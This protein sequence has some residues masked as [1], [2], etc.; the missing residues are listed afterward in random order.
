MWVQS[1]GG[2]ILNTESVNDPVVN[3]IYD[4]VEE[5]S[6]Q[7]YEYTEAM[8]SAPPLV[9]D[10]LHEGFRLL[11]D[12]NGVVLAG[13]ELEADWGYKFITWQ[14]TPDRTAMTQG[15]YYDG[16]DKYEAA[17]L[18]FACRTGLVQESRQFSNEQLAEV[19][20]CVH[21]TLDSEYPITDQRHKV[22]EQVA[23]QIESSVDDLD[24]LVGQSNQQ[25]LEAAQEQGRDG[26]DMEF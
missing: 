13:Q 3:H 7:V 22:L 14:R 11:A 15:N 9:A 23:E 20:R 24:E 21:K 19:Y 12:F 18:D 10:G 25:E 4:T 16:G 26:P 8:A 6:A 2:I 1:W 5:I 17:K